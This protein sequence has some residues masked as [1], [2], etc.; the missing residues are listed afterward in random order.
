MPRQVLLIN[1]PNL[2]LVGTREPHIYG[3]ATLDDVVAQAK[4]QEKTLD[5]EVEAFQ[6]NHEGTIVDRLH[7]REE[8]RKNIFLSE[9][10]I[11]FLATRQRLSLRPSTSG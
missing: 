5:A 6:S 7:A 8:F 9:A 1:G 4:L 2:N 3:A 11:W 10:V